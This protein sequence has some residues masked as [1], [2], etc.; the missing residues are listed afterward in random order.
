[1]EKA[2]RRA[3]NSRNASQA[4]ILRSRQRDDLFANNLRDNLSE[5]LH[6]I[7]GKKLL[8]Q[9][10]Q[11]ELPAKLAYFIV[12]TG[13]NNQTIGEEYT[14]I[15]QADVEAR[16][17]PSLGARTLAVL[18][19]FF[20]EQA[21]IKLLERLLTSINH[22]QSELRP[23]AVNFLNPFLTRLKIVIPL[24]IQAHR[25]LFYIFGRYY[26]LGK[27]LT[28]VNYVKVYGR[29]PPE[30]INWALRLLGAATLAQCALKLW[31]MRYLEDPKICDV[32]NDFKSALGNCQLCLEAV[33][34]S[35]T[36]CGHLFCWQCLADWLSSRPQCPLCR[37][38]AHPSRIIHLL[39][40]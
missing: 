28:G 24:M 29:R 18:F 25:G 12:T 20:G 11:S 17:I 27:R 21:L 6:K 14:G 22:P 38:Y 37:E 35:A 26:T 3:V 39:N 30:Q 31:R 4:E 8:L 23:E 33:P 19:E 32:G 16:K 40:M 13:M 2:T 7:G 5:L 9:I 10:A 36:P 15:I 34:T 1:M